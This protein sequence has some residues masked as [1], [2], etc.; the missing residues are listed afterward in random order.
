MCVSV[1]VSVCVGVCVHVCVNNLSSVGLELCTHQHGSQAFTPALGHW[2]VIIDVDYV[3]P[4][5]H[6]M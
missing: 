1:C 5:L 4:A 3:L 6:L 2:K